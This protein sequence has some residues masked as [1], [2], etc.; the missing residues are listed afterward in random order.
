MFEYEQA[1]LN[2]QNIKDE[3]YQYLLTSYKNDEVPKE[4]TDKTFK[5]LEGIQDAILKRERLKI[6]FSKGGSPM[7]YKQLFSYLAKWI[8]EE[9]A[10]DE[11]LTEELDKIIE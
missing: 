1:K 9:Y 2:L 4:T 11:I 3:L 8:E 5:Y 6:E 7:W 10:L